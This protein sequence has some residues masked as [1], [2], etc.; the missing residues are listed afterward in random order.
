MKQFFVRNGKV[1]WLSEE[2][3]KDKFL[4]NAIP[5]QEYIKGMTPE[6][7]EAFKKERYEKFLKPILGYNIQEIER[8]QAEKKSAPRKVI[9]RRKS[10]WIDPN[11]R[12]K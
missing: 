6:E 7:L 11:N 8:K 10:W 1:Q 12:K 5:V 9:E 2:E 4:P 3:D